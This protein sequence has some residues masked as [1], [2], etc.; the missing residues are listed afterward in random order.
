MLK[1]ALRQA[2]VLFTALLCVA[3]G[4]FV[5]ADIYVPAPPSGVGGNPSYVDPIVSYSASGKN[6]TYGEWAVSGN[7]HIPV[8]GFEYNGI[9]YLPTPNEF[10]AGEGI[11]VTGAGTAGAV[12]NTTVSAYS[13][14]PIFTTGTTTVNSTTLTVGSTAGW[15]VG[16]GIEIPGALGEWSVLE[17][18]VTAIGSGTLTLASQATAVV[19]GVQVQSIPAITL[20]AAPSTTAIG[21]VYAIGSI[22]SG[23]PTLTLATTAGWQAGYGITVA[24]AGTSGALLKT[25]VLAVASSTTLTLAANA[26]TT[27]TNAEINYDDTAAMLSALASQKNLTVESGH[28]NVTGQMTLTFPQIV[29]C[30]GPGTTVFYNRG[31]TNNVFNIT[32]SNAFVRDCTIAQAIDVTPTAGYAEVM[33]V[34]VADP[35]DMIYGG[36]FEHTNTIDTYG[37]QQIN[38]GVIY[39]SMFMNRLYGGPAAGSSAISVNNPAPGGD[40]AWLGEDIEC[41]SNATNHTGVNFVASDSNFWVDNS[42][43]GCDPTITVTGGANANRQ[44]F[45]ANS[46]EPSLPGVQANPTVALGGTSTGFLFAADEFG[47]ENGK[48]TF[49]MSGTSAVVIEANLAS[50]TTGAWLTNSPSGADITNWG[51]GLGNVAAASA[52]PS[53]LST[54][55]EFYEPVFAVSFLMASQGPPTL[56]GGS[57]SGSAWLGTGSTAG[58]FTAASCTAGTYELSNLGNYVGAG[59]PA[60][61][62]LWPSGGRLPS[63]KSERPRRPRRWRKD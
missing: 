49:S 43:V 52:S 48:G 34:G 9:G 39:A 10:V 54:E 47:A 1:Q 5:R 7:T 55:M 57:C 44:Y 35:S 15:S 51:N 60:K 18:T 16:M 56:T 30:S 41:E 19:T 13:Y 17:T 33:G 23:S 31:T 36:G 46:I 58:S 12:L 6:S 40:I 29:Q 42:I 28:Y 27:V 26:G 38:Q 37:E 4:Y 53:S 8:Y 2:N 22:N 59:A 24:G 25:T 61:A 32:T 11:A 20:A 50:G 62:A 45:V 14:T 63:P 21:T 3:L